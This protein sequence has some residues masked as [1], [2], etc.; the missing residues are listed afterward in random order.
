[1]ISSEKLKSKSIFLHEV[2]A[3]GLWGR[4]DGSHITTWS[5]NPGEIPSIRTTILTTGVPE[6]LRAKEGRHAG[7]LNID[8]RQFVQGDLENLGIHQIKSKGEMKY[9]IGGATNTIFDKN[10]SEIST[11]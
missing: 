8:L 7:R 4:G 11:E 2:V 10:G 6:E 9:M 5:E 1:M 3:H